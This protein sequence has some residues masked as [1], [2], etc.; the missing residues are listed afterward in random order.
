M[1]LYLTDLC[2]TLRVPR[3]LAARQCCERRQQGLH[4]N[5]E[6]K[7][8]Y[9]EGTREPFVFKRKKDFPPVGGCFFFFCFF[10]FSPFSR[11]LG[12]R[13]FF[14]FR[15][16]PKGPFFLGGGGLFL[17]QILIFASL[18]F[19]PLLFVDLFSHKVARM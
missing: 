5:V 2:D 8:G 3:L 10:I 18:Y 14:L 13:L 1:M 6:W 17:K 19:N 16:V 7:E 4:G 12:S 15:D 11:F 9:N